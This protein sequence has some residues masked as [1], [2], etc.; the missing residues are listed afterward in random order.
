M[1]GRKNSIIN[2]TNNCFSMVSS[3]KAKKL[4]LVVACT[5]SFLQ[6]ISGI[7]VVV[8]YGQYLIS[9]GFLRYFNLLYIIEF[10]GCLASFQLLKKYTRKNLLQ[11]GAI[12][13]C[14]L[15][16]VAGFSFMN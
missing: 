12:S 15:S 9:F 2:S 1:I 13:T 8:L 5:V 6:Q 14:I 11:F 7:N 16:A 10:I 4:C 3:P